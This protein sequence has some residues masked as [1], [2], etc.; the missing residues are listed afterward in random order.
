MRLR[1]GGLGGLFERGCVIDGETI[2]VES[3][4]GVLSYTGD[5][6]RVTRCLGKKFVDYEWK[7]IEID[8]DA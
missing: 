4:G 8:V 5:T 6:V 3:I 7:V 2:F 1:R